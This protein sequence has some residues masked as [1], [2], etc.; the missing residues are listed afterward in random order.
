MIFFCFVLFRFSA[1]ESRFALGTNNFLNL[2]IV[3][4]NDYEINYGFTC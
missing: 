3:L 1:F 2:L 4:G